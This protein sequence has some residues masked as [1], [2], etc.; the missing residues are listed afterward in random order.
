MYLSSILW[1]LVW[2]ALIIVSYFAVKF[3]LKKANL[4]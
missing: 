1:L 3:F 4:L 2:P